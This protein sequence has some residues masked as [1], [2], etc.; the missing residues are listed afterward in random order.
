MTYVFGGDK[1][2]NRFARIECKHFDCT[3]SKHINVL[4]K[5]TDN[6]FILCKHI[7]HSAAQVLK[8][9]AKLAGASFKALNL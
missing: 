6:V 3:K 8:K 5:N 2:P 1:L 4:I 7:K 9:K